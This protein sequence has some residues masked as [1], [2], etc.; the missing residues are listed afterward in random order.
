MSSFRSRKW[1]WVRRIG[2]IFGLHLIPKKFI[3]EYGEVNWNGLYD[4]ERYAAVQRAASAAKYDMVWAKKDSCREIV[5]VIDDLQ[6]SYESLLCHGVRNGAELDYFREFGVSQVLGTDLFVPATEITRKD[7]VEHDFG[8]VNPAWLGKFDCV[9][10]N[11]F[12]HAR[13]PVETIKMW[14]N[15]VKPTGCV[16]LE[17]DKS[18][19]V[20]GSSDLD[21]VGFPLNTFPFWL[22]R[23]S[24]NKIYLDSIHDLPRGRLLLIV[25]KK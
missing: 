19:G 16:L 3:G 17:M 11:S 2:D 5:S 10:S 12:D 21:V 8:E 18:H 15:Q 24:K 22:L 1:R 4:R 25:K 13:N 14:T 23:E 20:S 7:I 6:Y 9:Y